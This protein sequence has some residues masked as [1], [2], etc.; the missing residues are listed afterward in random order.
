MSLFY[1]RSIL[2]LLSLML[3]ASCSI[4]TKRDLDK[5]YGQASP[6]ERFSASADAPLYHQSRDI[7]DKRCV[8]CHACYDAPCQLK[9]SSI[10]GIDRGANKSPVYDGLRLIADDPTRLFEY[11]MDSEAWRK[12]DFYPV[13]NERQQDPETNLQLSLMYQ[14]L[15]QKR[16]V[17]LPNTALLPE[18]LD[19]SMERE[20]S[21]PKIEEYPQYREDHAFAG[22]PFGLP[23]LDDEEFVTLERWLATGAR[24]PL[25][26]ALDARQLGWLNKWEA[27]FNAPALKNRLVSRYIY[28]HL[29]LANLYFV[30]EQD[31]TTFFR[32]VRS[33]TPPGEPIRMISTRRPFDSPYVKTDKPLAEDGERFFYRLHKVT[34][35]IVSKTHMPYRIDQQRMD[36][37]QQ[38]FFEVPY[39]VESLPTYDVKQASNPFITFA[40]IPVKSRYKFMLEEAQH[41]I[42]NYIKGP[43]CRGQ[44]ALDVINDHFWVIFV[45]PDSSHVDMLDPFL[46]EHAELLKFPAYWDNSAGLFSWLELSKL[47]LEFM[48]AKTDFFKKMLADDAIVPDIHLIWDGYQHQNDNA[49]LTIMR[50]F[51]SATVVK[52]FA[53]TPP[54]TSWLIG[55]TLLERIHYLL[56][57]GFD[58][59]GTVSHQLITRL[60]ME[61]LRMEGEAAF[62]SVLPIDQQVQTKERWYEDA[63]DEVDRHFN[64]LLDHGIQGQGFGFKTQDA[65]GE[66]YEMLTE[67]T[68]AARYAISPDSDTNIDAAQLL[69]LHG[70]TGL[71]ASLLAEVSI[72]KVKNTQG[73]ERFFTLLSHRAHKNLSHL[74]SEEETRL[75]EKDQLN[76]LPGII[77]PYP[78]AYMQLSTEDLPIF[79]ERIQALKTEA[80][81]AKLMDQ[82]GMR[83]TNK[84]FWAFS[85]EL[86]TY[87]RQQAGFE[88]GLLDYNRLENR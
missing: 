67:H 48:Q 9:M 36:F 73:D 80:D 75:P 58:V 76:I 7:L 86:H 40:D 46:R 74:L 32:L 52:G 17:P 49:A 5:Q 22:M 66:L 3:L 14:L 35:T 81:Y 29:Y 50:H 10:E 60:Y 41:A 55:Y 69:V 23:G 77:S 54:K 6:I 39:K 51:D 24:V 16:D 20:T 28:E 84:D 37:W 34:S 15:Q 68:A 42:M 33:Y 45:D 53:G 30:D 47:S 43:V 59:N 8:V 26:T 11:A 56:V 44:I 63:G 2:L 27:F 12:K 85:D 62:I 1:F 25:R 18:S 82:F 78:N 4:L 61:F 57:A 13:L 64:V 65:Q 88:F 71:Q 87:F 38:I 79:V 83:R 70:L 72:L 21:C 31:Q 19:V